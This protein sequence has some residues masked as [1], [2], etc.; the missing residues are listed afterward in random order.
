[1]LGSAY[2]RCRVHFLRNAFAVI[3][4]EAGEMVAATIRTI[5]AQPTAEAVRA[6]LDTVADMLGRQFPKVQD[7]L[8]KAKTAQRLYSAKACC[9]TVGRQTL[10]AEDVSLRRSDAVPCV[11]YQVD[12]SGPNTGPRI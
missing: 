10:P 1:M 7:M 6:Q 8:L 5:F 2:Q 12:L 3:H 4:K 9:G 11:G